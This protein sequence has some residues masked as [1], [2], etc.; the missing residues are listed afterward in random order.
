MKITRREGIALLVYSGVF[1]FL[2]GGKV[3]DNIHRRIDNHRANIWKHT[4]ETFKELLEMSYEERDKLKK[5][6]ESKGEAK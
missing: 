2:V 6:L 3:V 4:A 5:E 1:G